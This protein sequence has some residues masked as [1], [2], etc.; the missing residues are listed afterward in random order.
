[1]ARRGARESHRPRPADIGDH[2]AAEIVP[3]QAAKV[4]RDAMINKRP[5]DR[6]PGDGVKRIGDFE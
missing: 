1:M 6:R 2:P 5:L 3:D 4:E